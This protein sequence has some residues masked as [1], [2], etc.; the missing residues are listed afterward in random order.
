MNFALTAI[1]SAI[2]MIFVY[3]LMASICSVL[4]EL[5]A[6]ITSW[7]GRHLRRSIQSMLNDPNLTGLAKRLYS[8]P[9][10]ATLSFAGKLPSYIPSTTF[11]AALA[12][13]L[14]AE[15]SNLKYVP[16]GPLAPFVKDAGGKIDLLKQDLAKWFEESTDTLGGWYKRNVQIVLLLLALGLA[17]ILNVDT[18]A[19][20]SA[21]WTQP[22]VRDAVV[23]LADQ[24][25]AK[26]KTAE[27]ID[28]IRKQ[29]EALPL[30]IGWSAD[31][32]SCLWGKNAF[33]NAKPVAAAENA[34]C[35]TPQQRAAAIAGGPVNR[36]FE[37]SALLAGWIVTALATSLGTQF[38]FHALQQALQLRA[39]GPKPLTVSEKASEATSEKVSVTTSEK[40]SDA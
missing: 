14:A 2:G 22:A 27:Q 33:A 4:Q 11:A 7:R 10:V 39:A 28:A 8:H 12:D 32:W 13:I 1:D 26:D 3:L 6:N 17:G 40:A 20:A 36:W 5:I 18:F 38:W 31:A 25:G 34:G 30:P 23:K 16:D 37:W 15:T 24:A 35:A 29:L 19:I 21:L 9:R